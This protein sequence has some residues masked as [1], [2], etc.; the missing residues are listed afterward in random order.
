ML[1]QLPATMPSAGPSPE[2]PRWADG[3]LAMV[4]RLHLLLPRSDADDGREVAADPLPTAA[5]GYG[6]TRGG[7]ENPWQVDESARKSGDVSVVTA[8]A[9][10]ALRCLGEVFRAGLY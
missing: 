1:P 3:C 5:R 10:D 2:H 9:T 8:M 7:V 4:T 6:D